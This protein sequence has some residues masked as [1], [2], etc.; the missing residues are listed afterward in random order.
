MS[1]ISNRDALVNERFLIKQDGQLVAGLEYTNRA[2]AEFTRDMFGPGCQVVTWMDGI[3]DDLT[4]KGWRCIPAARVAGKMQPLGG[5]IDGQVYPSTA[6]QWQ[7]AEAIAVALPADYLLID[8]DGYKEGAATVGQIADALGLTVDQL[9]RAKVQERARKSS[10]HWVF[11]L[12]TT[13]NIKASTGEWLP[14]VDI[15]TGNSNGL[16]YIKPGK[17]AAF[18]TVADVQPLPV[19]VRHPLPVQAPEVSRPCAAVRIATEPTPAGLVLLDDVIGKLADCPEGGRNDSLNSA[20]VRLAHYVAGGELPGEMVETRLIETAKALGLSER[21][22]AATVRS[23][24]RKGASEPQRLTATI[25]AEAFAQPIEPPTA[26]GDY[27]PFEAVNVAPTELVNDQL[28]DARLIYGAA[29]QRLA[30]FEGEPH[31]WN[32]REWEPVDPLLLRRHVARAMESDQSKGIRVNKS[33]LD[34][35]LS[36]LPL[37]AP[38]LGR[39][40]PPSKTVFFSSGAFNPETGTLAPHDPANANSRTLAVDYDPTAVAPTWRAWLADIFQS[41]P[42][43][44][45]LLQEIMGWTLCRDNLGIEKAAIMIGPSR[46][47]KGTIIR[48]MQALLQ[49]AAGAF[50]LP[51]LADDK[52]LSSMREWALAIDSEAASPAK[53]N[54]RQVVARFKAITSNERI[55]VKLLYTQKTWQGSLD[56]KLLLAANSVPTMWDD[57]GATGNRWIPLVFDRSFLGKEDPTLAERLITEL[58]GIAVWALEGLQ[59]LM[60]QGRFTLP[61]SSRNELENMIQS[62]S[63]VEQF[64]DECLTFGADHRIADSTIWTAYGAWVARTGHDGMKRH[65]LMKALE[66]ATRAK[67][68]RRQKSVRIGISDHRGFSC[69][70]S[71]ATTN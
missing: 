29:L 11:R 51:E 19:A 21:E 33:R 23:G 40:N 26:G 45:G 44:I 12:Q 31:W 2:E 14:S 66:D 17:V 35:T 30:T 69:T 20:A 60:A 24:M 62:G 56:C 3:R 43:R 50:Q 47:G 32:G 10:V 59:R 34:G 55:P 6:K 7:S 38:M 63:P 13:V 61:E 57:S 64:I 1:S 48:V 39:L 71:L 54:A 28:T 58:P 15:K 16:V 67:G 25:A 5:Y 9:N 37:I 68:V 53:V 70:G 49:G 41:E 36:M 46:S 22:A 27:M 4:A 8:L 52:N 42:E 65:N 18:P